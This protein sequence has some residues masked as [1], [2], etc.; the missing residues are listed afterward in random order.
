MPHDS[1]SSR[2]EGLQ[3][4][5]IL[6][7]ARRDGKAIDSCRRSADTR[8]DCP[9]EAESPEDH[10]TPYPAEGAK[11]MIKRSLFLH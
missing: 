1:I 2:G 4:T 6:N 11:I 3:E 10:Y 7:S 8:P 9:S 5:A